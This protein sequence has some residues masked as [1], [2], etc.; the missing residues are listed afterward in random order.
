MG[1]AQTLAALNA[2]NPLEYTKQ[3]ILTGVCDVKNY[4]KCLSTNQSLSLYPLHLNICQNI[5][6]NR[7]NMTTV[8]VYIQEKSTFSNEISTMEDAWWFIS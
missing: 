6:N 8:L 5:R 7:F 3:M 4:S 2:I 1:N